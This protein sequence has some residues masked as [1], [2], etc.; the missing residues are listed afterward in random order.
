MARIWHLL[1]VGVAIVVIAPTAAYADTGG[2][3]QAQIQQGTCD[4]NTEVGDDTVTIGVDVE[5]PGNSGGGGGSP[6]PDP[7]EC[8]GVGTNGVCRDLYDADGPVTLSDIAHFR[9]NPGLNLMQPDGWMIVGLHTNFY[10]HANRHVTSGHLLGEPAWVRFT[11]IG[12]QW[13][14]GDSSTHY[15]GTPGNTW[16]NLGIPE[17]DRTPNSHI[18]QAPGTYYIDLTITYRAEYRYIGEDFIPI[19]GTLTLP[20]NRLVAVAGDA[21]TVLVERDCTTNRG[22]P[23]C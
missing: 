3:S 8:E 5:T 2:C 7:D 13:W 12:Y 14:Y 4:I 21:V 16:Q 1:C 20:A 10:A 6:E 17:F 23:G 18:Y 22:G 9:P 19:A 15:S 11:P